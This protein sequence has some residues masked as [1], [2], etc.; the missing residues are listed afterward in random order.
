[1]LARELSSG[2]LYVEED[3]GTEDYTHKFHKYLTLWSYLLGTVLNTQLA[4]WSLSLYFY[5]I[6][7][8]KALSSADI[9]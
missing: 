6:V 7:V 4:L 1:M 9:L 8:S 5:E 3:S 2:Q